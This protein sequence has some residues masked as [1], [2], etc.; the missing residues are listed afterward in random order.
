LV[1]CDGQR[2]AFELVEGGLRS[3]VDAKNQASLEQNRILE[4]QHV[5]L[6]ATRRDLEL[7]TR[8]SHE[9]GTQ[10][11]KLMLTTAKSLDEIELKQR[12]TGQ[13]IE[14]LRSERACLKQRLLDVSQA[15][16]AK[17]KEKSNHVAALQ[18]QVHELQE[19]GRAK[20]QTI[21][22]LSRAIEEQEKEQAFARYKE[23]D[24]TRCHSAVQITYFVHVS[25]RSR[26]RGGWSWR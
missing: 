7:S 6:I 19:E 24:S 16:A 20:E 8:R 18:K 12:Q 13:A 1:A 5:R 14:L 9:L 3:Q 11:S 4:E 17:L 26:R 21:S 22:R 25:L 2:A 23:T 15:Y 10:L